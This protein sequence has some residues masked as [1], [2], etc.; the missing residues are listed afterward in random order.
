[1]STESQNDY[2]DEITIIQKKCVYILWGIHGFLLAYM[3]TEFTLY[4]TTD[5]QVLHSILEVK[6]SL[7]VNIMSPVMYIKSNE[8]FTVKRWNLH[9]YSI[10]YGITAGE[11]YITSSVFRAECDYSVK[12][13]IFQSCYSLTITNWMIQCFKT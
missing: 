6:I 8:S 13:E 5:N 2:D 10:E 11:V 7:Q 3:S 4:F 1:M 9:S 12:H